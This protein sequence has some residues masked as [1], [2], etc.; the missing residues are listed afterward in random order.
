MIQ[1][2]TSTWDCMF[3]RGK[4]RQPSFVVSNGVA[5][6]FNPNAQRPVPLPNPTWTPV[7]DAYLANQ[8]VHTLLPG[9]ELGLPY[10]LVTAREIFA[11]G[12]AS[13]SGGY[14]QMSAVG[15]DG[16]GTRAMVYMGYQCGGLCGGGNLHLLEKV[17]GGWRE[18]A[19]LCVSRA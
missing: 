17:N 4:R 7:L 13:G 2:E 16:A 18:A 15:F 8:T 3:T 12:L 19:K 10:K 1:H 14:F 11:L 9:R 6:P 5:R